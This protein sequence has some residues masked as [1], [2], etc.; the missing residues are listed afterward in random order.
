MSLLTNHPTTLIIFGATGDLAQTKIFPAL[1]DLLQAGVLPPDF[2]IVAFARKT[3]T[4]TEYKEMVGR[5]I[6]GSHAHITP[7]VLQDLLNRVRYVR[8]DFDDDASYH[9]LQREL[10][11][12]DKAAH[13]SCSNKLFYLAIPPALYEGVLNH[14][15]LSG[16]SIPCADKSGW[17]RILLEKPFGNDLKTARSLDHLLG[18]L[19]KEEQ[20]FRIDH[21]LA[22]E[23]VQNILAFRFSNALFEPLWNH[24][25]I[26]RVELVLSE[27]KTVGTRAPFYEGLGALKD[28]GQNHALQMLALI[29][30]E[31]PDSLVADDIRR[32][33]AQ[34]LQALELSTSAPLVRAQYDSYRAEDGVSIHS[35]TE[36]AFLLSA[37]V[38]TSRWK[39]VPF[40]IMS[41]K[42][43]A[44]GDALIRV[45][46][47]KVPWCAWGDL[48]CEQGNRLT[49]RI[50]PKEGIAISFLAKQPGLEGVL[51]ER[52]LSFS[53]DSV[54]VSKRSPGAYERVLADCVRGDQT[55]FASTDEVDASWKFIGDTMKAWQA[56]PLLSYHKGITIEEWVAE[57]SR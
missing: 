30:M 33:R 24:E 25:Y 38:H 15:A 16:L 55:L 48:A 9:T 50:Q 31:R 39:G 49:F 28:V 19:F 37:H 7:A 57:V 18:L 23:T 51:E 21:Y 40:T 10:V 52:E 6:Q 17:T 54:Q 11:S 4:D 56:H 34:T 27:S 53:Y 46:F 1:A 14:I 22:K 12:I 29:A 13:A 44:A 41:G 42:A 20:I 2:Y 32:K 26:E 3:F 5:W 43:F 36:T 47:K 35:D 8:G 45:Y